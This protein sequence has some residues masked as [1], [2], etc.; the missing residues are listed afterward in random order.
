MVIDSRGSRIF[1][2]FRKFHLVSNEMRRNMEEFGNFS[3]PSRACK[4][5]PMITSATLH[6]Y[7][8]RCDVD[9]N[10]IFPPAWIG[11]NG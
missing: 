6:E 7:F 10:R 8:R 4:A 9:S 2:I 5:L 11:T 3:W 1:R